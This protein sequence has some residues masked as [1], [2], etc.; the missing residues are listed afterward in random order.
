LV[1]PGL[2]ADAAAQAR[3]RRSAGKPR[4]RY[5]Q[6]RQLRLK[7]A[8]RVRAPRQKSRINCV[9]STLGGQPLDLPGAVRRQLVVE[10][11]DV[12][13]V[14]AAEAA[15][16]LILPAPWKVDPVQPFLQHTGTAAA[17]AA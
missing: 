4:R 8:S 5:F 16:I 14:S 3:Q 10:D 1:S 9:R 6:L 12:D 11:D 13:A 2:H 17:P 7:L 15:R